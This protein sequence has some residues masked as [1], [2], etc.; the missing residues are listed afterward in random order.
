MSLE[1]L[2]NPRSIAMIGA[3]DNA[4]RI[5]GMPLEL[6]SHFGFAG[7]VYPVNPKYTE[8]FG[9]RCYAQV[10]D[11]PAV[12]DLAVLAIGARDVTAM[13]RRCHAIGIRAAVV[14]AAGFAEEAP[15]ACCCSRSWCSFAGK[16]ACR[17]WS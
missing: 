17:C 5:G 1:P 7:E 6:L 2:L 14:Y 3:S 16:A 13:L 8:V 12:P 11:L 9:Y 4:G 10:E 15:P